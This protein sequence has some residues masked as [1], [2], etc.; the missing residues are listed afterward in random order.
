M[1]DESCPRCGQVGYKVSGLVSS[2]TTSHGQT[3]LAAKLSPPAPPP[4]YESPWGCFSVA[5]VFLALGIAGLSV[6][7]IVY[8]WGWVEGG[9]MLYD[10]SVV[11]GYHVAAIVIVPILVITVVSKVKEVNARKDYIRYCHYQYPRFIRVWNALYYCPHHDIVFLPGKQN[12]YASASTQDA[13]Q[14][15]LYQ[16]SRRFL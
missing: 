12:A 10:P 6:T 4:A 5:F 7:A 11:I 15:A 8:F 13:F 14:E 9:N 3:D 2:G 1:Q 16:F